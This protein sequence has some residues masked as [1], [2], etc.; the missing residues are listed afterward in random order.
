MSRFCTFFFDDAR[1]MLHIHLNNK[2]ISTNPQEKCD[3]YE[4][5]KV[6]NEYI[7]HAKMN[8]NLFYYKLFHNFTQKLGMIMTTVAMLPF[9]RLFYKIPSSTDENILGVVCGPHTGGI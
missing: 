2:Y 4:S 9:M 7:Y 6:I 5:L 3:G 1:I 8:L